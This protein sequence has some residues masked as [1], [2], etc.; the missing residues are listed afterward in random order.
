[1]IFSR[2]LGIDFGEARIGVAISDDLRLM[3]HPLETIAVKAGKPLTRIA[4][5]IRDREIGAVIIGL[6]RN[7]DGSYGASAEKARSFAQKIGELIAP[8]PVTLWDERL[9]TV[10]AS[11]SLRDAGKNA[12]QQKGV[13]DQAAAQVILQGWLDR[14]ALLDSTPD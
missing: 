2:V 4:T 14:Q 12:R 10:A 3:A 7:M 6:P 1:M 9:S 5:L 8:I 13:I 11:R